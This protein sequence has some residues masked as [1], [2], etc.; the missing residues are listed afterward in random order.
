MQI[1]K[2]DYQLMLTVGAADTIAKLCPDGEL[3]RMGELLKAGNT[4]DVVAE[5]IVAMANG[6]DDFQTLMGEE[7]THPRLTKAMVMSLPFPELRKLQTEMVR[8]FAEDVTARVE[9]APSKKNTGEL[10]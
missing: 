6:Y 9:V 2:H 8:K 4:L 1:G 7:I 5:L 10:S 3:S